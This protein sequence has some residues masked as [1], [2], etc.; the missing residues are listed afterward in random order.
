MVLLAGCVAYT[1]KPTPSPEITGDY[2]KFPKYEYRAVKIS[3]ACL[4]DLKEAAR[5]AP[6]DVG[7]TVAPGD[8]E[9]A[10]SAFD[11]KSVDEWLSADSLFPDAMGDLSADTI[12][13]SL[14]IG[15]LCGSLGPTRAATSLLCI[16]DVRL[17]L[18]SGPSSFL[19]GDRS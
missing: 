9:L 19:I 7:Q 3:E 5:L 11:C 2:S 6:T 10:A 8:A 16:D 1:S 13:P 15:S 18:D 4:A 17:G 12:V 14:N